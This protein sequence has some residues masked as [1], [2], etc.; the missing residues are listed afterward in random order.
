MA[1]DRNREVDEH[2][3][4]EPQG[5]ELIELSLSDLERV[6]AGMCDMPG[7]IDIDK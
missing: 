4:K 6:G 3:A 5:K 2:I 7:T 1:M